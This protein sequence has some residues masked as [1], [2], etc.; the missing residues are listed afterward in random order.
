MLSSPSP[1]SLAFSSYPGFI[2]KKGA[3]LVHAQSIIIFTEAVV[4]IVYS[5][6]AAALRLDL[7]NYI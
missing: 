3:D 6:C 2:T 1:S 4:M 5:V 7:I